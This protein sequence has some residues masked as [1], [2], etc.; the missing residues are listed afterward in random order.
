MTIRLCLA[1]MMTFVASRATAG[2]INF[3][4]RL[5]FPKYAEHKGVF[6]DE[7]IRRYAA[8][9]VIRCDGHQ[10]TAQFT[11]SL[12]WLTTS[13]HLF[14][15]RET[16]QPLAKPE[17]CV[18]TVRTVNHQRRYKGFQMAD[19]GYSK[20]LEAIKRGDAT[21]PK[22]GLDWGDDWAILHFTNKDAIR[23]MTKEVHAYKIPMPSD[24]HQ[25]NENVVAVAGAALDFFDF[26]PDGVK[27]YPRNLQDCTVRDITP[28]SGN[29]SY[30]ETDCDT[31]E[32][33]SGGSLLR[34]G[35]RG[36]DTLIGIHMGSF[37]SK[38]E[39][40]QALLENRVNMKPYKRG[41]W[42]AIYVSLTGDF[43]QSLQH[44][45]GLNREI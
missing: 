38:A 24:V 45:L 14:F 17:D 37:E 40:T 32:L 10:A 28:F 11:G 8:T 36:S 20:K 26:T 34:A 42:S 15:N 23:E 29:G 12:E 30:V 33:T 19:H 16:C 6:A 3:P 9:V 41:A 13:D 5:T 25:E 7:I 35:R 39:L 43:L 18:I 44:L 4:K 1:M 31:A 27:F 2:V 21:C 22:G